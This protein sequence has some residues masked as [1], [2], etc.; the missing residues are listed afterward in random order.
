MS[1]NTGAEFDRCYMQMQVAS[2]V[3]CKDMIEVFEIDASPGLVPTL[4]AGHKLITE[5]LERAKTLCKQLEDGAAGS[6][7]ADGNSPKD[8]Q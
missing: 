3:R 8:E 4:D 2:H 5:H 6:N 1:S 7:G